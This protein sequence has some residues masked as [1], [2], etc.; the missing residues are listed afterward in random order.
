VLPRS[1]TNLAKQRWREHVQ[2]Q[3]EVVLRRE[4]AMEAPGAVAHPAC[5]Q[6]Q[7]DLILRTE[8]QGRDQGK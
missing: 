5:T 3:N 1:S 6:V 4:M 8:V 2:A 7:H